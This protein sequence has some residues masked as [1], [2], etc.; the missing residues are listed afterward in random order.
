MKINYT[1]CDKKR[2]VRICDSFPSK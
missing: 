2:Y 1:C